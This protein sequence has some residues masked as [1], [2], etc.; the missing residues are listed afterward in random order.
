[1]IVV[2]IL[3]GVAIGSL[4]IAFFILLVIS[5]SVVKSLL[6]DKMV[7]TVERKAIDGIY[8]LLKLAALTGICGFA[9]YFLLSV[10]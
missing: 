7:Y 9:L 4:I 2:E 6:K 10:W 5:P 1:M 8:G 3:L